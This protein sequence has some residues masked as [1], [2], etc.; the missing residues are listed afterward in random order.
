MNEVYRNAMDTLGRYL[1]KV[2]QI[3]N[4]FFLI[5]KWCGEPVL[6]FS[7][8]LHTTLDQSPRIKTAT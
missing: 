2:L 4:Q 8:L 1:F 6:T 5:I 7:M 3:Q